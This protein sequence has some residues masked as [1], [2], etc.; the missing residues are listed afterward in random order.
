MA[1]QGRG[2]KF[3]TEVL[4]EINDDPSLLHTTY[5]KVGNGGPLAT[6]F[7]HAFTAQGKF[8]LPDDEPPYRPNPNPLGMTQAIFQQEI[9]KWYVFCRA[10]LKAAKRE[11][12]F[13]QLLESM[14]P[15]EAKILL[16]IK[17]QKLS[18]LYP[19]ITR[20]VVADA[21][22]IPPLTAEELKQEETSVKK[23]AGPRGRPR[24]STSPQPAQSDLP[25]S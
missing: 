24:K 12:M 17:D 16:A 15:S 21:G 25:Q 11:I 22:F 7:K 9:Q 1:T 10:D 19:N 2:N 8:I 23:S 18:K 13:V 14:H 4:K 3:I 20:K 5:K 6:M